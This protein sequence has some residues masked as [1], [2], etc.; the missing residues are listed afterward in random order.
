MK[1]DQLATLTLRLMGIYCLVLLIPMAEMLNNA[2]IYA[3]NTSGGLGVVVIIITLLFLLGWLAVGISLIVFS[4]SLGRRLS[5]AKSDEGNITG[6]AFEQVQILAF[7]VAG[8]LIF[9]GTLPSLLSNIVAFLYYIIQ[10]KQGNPHRETGW[11]FDR[12]GF[13]AAIG[14]F[15]KAGL[16]LWLFFGARGFANFWRALRN[17]GTPKAPQ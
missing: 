14:T 3:Q 13:V 5:P 8:V 15:L 1:A 10:L 11:L 12:F 17:F 9:A 4:V 6:I 16:G 2:V 7:A